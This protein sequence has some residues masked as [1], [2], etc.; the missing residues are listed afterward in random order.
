[1]NHFLAVDSLQQ[2]FEADFESVHVVGRDNRGVS[3]FQGGDGRQIPM[4]V[5]VE[6][7]NGQKRSPDSVKTHVLSEWIIACLLI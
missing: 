5:D 3:A 4:A 7:H 2:Q 1:M 6:D